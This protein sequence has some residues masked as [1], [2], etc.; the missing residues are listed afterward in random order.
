MRALSAL[1][2][3]LCIFFIIVLKISYNNLLCTEILKILQVTL[4]L[5]QRH[6]SNS[7]CF[8][9]MSQASDSSKLYFTLFSED[10]I[11]WVLWY[12]EQ[13]KMSNVCTICVKVNK[14]TSETISYLSLYIMGYQW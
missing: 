14:G 1:A 12:Q 8:P 10:S 11:E 6:M 13:I 3:F 4:S 2:H 5:W 9:A 7:A